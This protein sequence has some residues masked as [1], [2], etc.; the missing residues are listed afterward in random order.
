M[1]G[2]PSFLESLDKPHTALRPYKNAIFTHKAPLGPV[3]ALWWP[4]RQIDSI[5]DVVLLF[6][7][8]KLYMEYY[9]KNSEAM[10]EFYPRK[11][12]TSWLLSSFP[13]RYS[14]GF[15]EACNPRS[16]PHRPHAWCR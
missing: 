12:R 8:G 11:S 9:C 2:L 7:P 6:I 4:C 5:P 13:H 10:D 14:Q 1:S 3:H 16:C 15:G